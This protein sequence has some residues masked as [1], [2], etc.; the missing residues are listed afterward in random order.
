MQLILKISSSQD[1]DNVRVHSDGTTYYSVA[2][3]KLS[4]LQHKW[5]HVNQTYSLLAIERV[6]ASMAP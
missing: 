5:F 2:C 3:N 6:Q 1:Q 4:S